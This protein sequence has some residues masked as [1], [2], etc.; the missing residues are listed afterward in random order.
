MRA[1]LPPRTRGRDRH[2]AF[3]E[4]DDDCEGEEPELTDEWTV[5]SIDFECTQT[6]NEAEKVI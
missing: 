6:S 2:D 3:S 1:A 4:Q 5:S